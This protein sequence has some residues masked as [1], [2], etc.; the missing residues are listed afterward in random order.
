MATMVPPP[1]FPRP[2]I[3]TATGPAV[4]DAL[5]A[6]LGIGLWPR[7][8][9]TASTG[10]PGGEVWGYALGVPKRSRRAPSP[11]TQLPVP[12]APLTALN[13]GPVAFQDPAQYRCVRFVRRFRAG[14]EG[15]RRQL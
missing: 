3:A 7:A 9:E 14:L 15:P 6:V 4:D 12:F 11:N 5:F 2:R 1:P 8:S 10:R 13:H